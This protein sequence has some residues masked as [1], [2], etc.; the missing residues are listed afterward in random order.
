MRSVDKSITVKATPEEV[1]RALTEAE[2]LKRWFPLDGGA[3]GG[4][5]G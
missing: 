5:Q 1:W 4:A 3:S 2:E